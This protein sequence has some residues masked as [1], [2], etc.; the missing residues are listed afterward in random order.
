LFEWV[1]RNGL[2]VHALDQKYS[3]QSAARARPAGG[4]AKAFCPPQWGTLPYEISRS[5]S[6]L[7]VSVEKGFF[8]RRGCGAP[9]LLPAAKRLAKNT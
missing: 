8:F 4:R 2:P 7:A 6:G 5:V 3:S 1:A 9:P